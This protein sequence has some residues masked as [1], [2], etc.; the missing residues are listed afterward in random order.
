MMASGPIEMGIQECNKCE[1]KLRCS[2]CA[3]RPALEFLR[4][5][6]TC[7]SCTLEGC[8]YRPSKGEVRINCI[9]WTDDR[10]A[11]NPSFTTPVP[12]DFFRPC[13]Y[14]IVT[15]EKETHS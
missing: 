15:D 8:L 11:V 14:S 12:P 6:K 2:E 7:E 3:A 9:F 5:G 1:Y 13:S 10:G 4:H